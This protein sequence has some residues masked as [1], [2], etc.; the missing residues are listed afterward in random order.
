MRRAIA[1]WIVI[2]IDLHRVGA[3]AGNPAKMLSFRFLPDS[4]P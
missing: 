3:D 2:A 1:P 4:F